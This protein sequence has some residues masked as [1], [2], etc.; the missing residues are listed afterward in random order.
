[1]GAPMLAMDASAASEL[2]KRCPTV[3]R[4]RPRGSTRVAPRD[5]K[6]FLIIGRHQPS[7]RML[8]KNRTLPVTEAVRL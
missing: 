1:M 5:D 3:R 8:F 4:S 2:V 7:F 6:I